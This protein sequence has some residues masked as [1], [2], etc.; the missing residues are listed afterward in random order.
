MGNNGPDKLMGKMRFGDEGKRLFGGTVKASSSSGISG[1]MGSDGYP[2]GARQSRMTEPGNLKPGTRAQA[3][4]TTRIDP[5]GGTVN[6]KMAIRG[7]TSKALR[8]GK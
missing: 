2:K 8:G 1:E 4:N 7:A 5:D 6:A 3:G